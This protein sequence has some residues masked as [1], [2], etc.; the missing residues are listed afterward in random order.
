MKKIILTTALAIAS[1]V[2][3]A[4]TGV[5]TIS[6]NDKQIPIDFWY[7]ITDD[8]DFANQMMYYGD[9][10]GVNTYLIKLLSESGLDINTPSGFDS[11]KDPFWIVTYS[12]GYVTYIYLS[13]DADDMAYSWI[14][15][16]SK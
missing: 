1:L 2:A 8:K 10:V 3:N 13:K 9:S 11:A 12:S 14:T 7:V 5:L 15:T 16:Y 6:K 4:Q